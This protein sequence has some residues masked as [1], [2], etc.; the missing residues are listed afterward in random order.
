MPVA[1]DAGPQENGGATA[2]TNAAQSASITYSAGAVLV[3]TVSVLAG[4]TVSGPN[5]SNGLTWATIAANTAFSGGSRVIYAFWAYAASGGTTTCQASISGAGSPTWMT[6]RMSVTGVDS[7]SPVDVTDNTL[8]GYSLT[9]PQNSAVSLT[10][11]ADAL[12]CAVWSATSRTYS[13]DSGFTIG[14]SITT[15]PFQ[16]KIGSVSGATIPFTWTTGTILYAGLAFSLKEASGGATGQPFRKRWGGVQ[17]NAYTR[18]G[19]W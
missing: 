17:H 7:T 4:R 15:S 1:L 14:T 5:D 3:F 19:L 10:S 16:Y 11:V 8:G 13:A 2:G 12:I 6:Q 9:S 18:R